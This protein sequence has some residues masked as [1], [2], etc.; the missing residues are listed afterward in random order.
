MKVE[1]SFHHYKTTWTVKSRCKGTH[2]G[3]RYYIYAYRLGKHSKAPFGKLATELLQHYIDEGDVGAAV[4]LIGD[5]LKAGR[6]F[7]IKDFVIKMHPH[8]LDYTTVDWDEIYFNGL[9]RLNDEELEWHI[10]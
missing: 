3:R 10:L 9:Y 6:S 7:R 5:K 4:Q 2:N 1:F 8:D